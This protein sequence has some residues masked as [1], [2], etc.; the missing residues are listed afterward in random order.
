MSKAEQRRLMNWR[1][2]VLRHA[3]E[4]TKNLAQTCRYFGFAE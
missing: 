2:K 1:L 3:M 4:V